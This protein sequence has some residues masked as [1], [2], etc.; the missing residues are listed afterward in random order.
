MKIASLSLPP[1][2]RLAAAAALACTALS[3]QGAAVVALT[4]NESVGIAAGPGA[5]VMTSF[6]ATGG[7]FFRSNSNGNPDFPP[8]STFFHTYGFTTGLTYFGARVSGEGTFF[9]Q[10]SANYSD[11]YTNTSGA[12]QLVSFNFNVDSG[13]IELAGMG[14]GY[15]DLRLRVRFNGTAVA[16]DHGRVERTASGL[17]CVVADAD[18]GVLGGY[19]SSCNGGNSGAFGT[20]GAYTITQ[21]LGAGATLNVSY[22]II[23]EVA[24]TFT[25]TSAEHCSNGP[26]QPGATALGVGPGD[27]PGYSGC[28]NFHAIARSGDPAGLAPFNPGPFNFT[29]ANVPEPG[30]LALALVAL[31]ALVGLGA[32][33]RRTQRPMD[34]SLPSSGRPVRR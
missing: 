28:R 6:P 7:D 34:S 26:G 13:Q 32:S 11:S 21:L 17:S 9:G 5:D 33:A 8:G 3:S 1:L 18:I 29:A 23:A 15:A 2:A 31:V 4:A 30:S 10:T 19:L 27:V 20:S 12:A 16:Q 25:G 24:G 22:D 14:N